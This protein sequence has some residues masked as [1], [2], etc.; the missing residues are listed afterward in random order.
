LAP[1]LRN[2]LQAAALDLRPSLRVTLDAG[3]AAGALGGIVSGSGP[4]CVFLG[5]DRA[6]AAEIAGRVEA[7][8]TC[9]AAFAVAGPATVES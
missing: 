9:T 4:T 2:D 5:R 3:L 8:G 1:L 7:S 6:H